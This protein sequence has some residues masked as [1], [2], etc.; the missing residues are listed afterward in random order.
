MP[1]QMYLKGVRK[2]GRCPVGGGGF[3]DVWKGMVEG[4]VV[5]LKVPRL[6]CTGADSKKVEAVSLSLLYMPVQ[7]SYYVFVIANMQ[8]R[9]CLE[10]AASL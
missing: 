2:T 7:F 8:G 5:A 4:K 1:R 3:A 10:S 9:H 6:H